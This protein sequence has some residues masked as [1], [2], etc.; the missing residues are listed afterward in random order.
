MSNY[1]KKAKELQ[2][3][4]GFDVK[5]YSLSNNNVSDE[6]GILQVITLEKVLELASIY[7]DYKYEKLTDA[8]QKNFNIENIIYGSGSEDLIVRI[9]LILKQI[10]S[11]CILYPNFYR[12][13]ETAGPHIKIF[14]EYKK[15]SQFIDIETVKK[16]LDRSN[17]IRSLWITNPNP[18]IGKVFNKND[19]IK[20][21]K[22][23]SNILF[24]IDESAIDFIKNSE[25]FSLLDLSQQVENLIVLR[26]FSKL[27]G[28][29]G[30]RIG[31][32]TGKSKFLRDVNKIGPTFPLNTIAEYFAINILTKKELVGQICE[33]IEKNKSIIRRLLE[34]NPNISFSESITN[35]LFFGSNQLDIF[36][37]FLKLGIISLKLNETEGIKE[38]N[39]VRITIHSSEKSFNDLFISL[40]KFIN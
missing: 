18:M 1:L 5:D 3:F 13:M 40:S 35:C 15:Q 32:A 8:L 38:K 22:D 11:I 33:K 17:N 28:L 23:Y 16:H 39:F 34:K 25:L 7:P 20:M 21:I 24:I 30:L 19:L 37:E 14:T 10:G 6:L 12:I 31:F 29:A 26:S 27:Y 36:E 9:N 4:S 2:S